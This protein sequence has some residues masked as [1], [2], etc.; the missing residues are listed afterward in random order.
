MSFIWATL[1]S[2]LIY[3]KKRIHLRVDNG[4]DQ[5]VTSWNVAVANGQYHGGGSPIMETIGLLRDYD[6]Q[7]K[8]DLV[9]TL[10]GIP[11]DDPQG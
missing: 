11:L 7:P 3:N 10:A 8:K 4:Y 9:K 6:V 2:L 5:Q 1:V